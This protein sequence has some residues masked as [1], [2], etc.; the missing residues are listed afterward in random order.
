MR[1]RKIFSKRIEQASFIS[2]FDM[3]T[4]KKYGYKKIPLKI[5]NTTQIFVSIEYLPNL[6]D[7][8]VT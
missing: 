4:K 6:C 5:N 7:L 2:H 8:I 3:M 1:S